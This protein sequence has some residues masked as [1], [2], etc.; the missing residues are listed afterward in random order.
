MVSIEDST[1]AERLEVFGLAHG[2]SP[3]ERE[4]LT[5]LATGIDSRA[6]AERLVLSQH[7]VNDHVKAVLAKTGTASRGTLLA[8]VAGTG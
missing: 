3:R 5:E 7:T 8:R 2:L 1:P 4:V 6:L